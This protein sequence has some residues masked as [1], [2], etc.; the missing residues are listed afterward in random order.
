M[1]NESFAKEFME[2]NSINTFIQWIRYLRLNKCYNTSLLLCEFYYPM[3]S[4]NIY[5]LDEMG[6]CYYYT[7]HY[8]QS[9]AIYTDILSCTYL[10]ESQLVAF[11][12]NAHF[13]I[14]HIS[15][16]TEYPKSLVDKISS[17]VQPAGLVTLSI[18]TC[19]RYELFEKTVNSFLNHCIDI[20]LISRW[21][22]IDD[23][24]SEQDRIKMRSKYPF[25]E[26]VWKTIDQ[27]G[28]ASSM[29]MIKDMVDTPF[30]FHLEDDW[31][32]YYKASYI[33]P[34]LHVLYNDSTLGQ[35]LLNKN[36]SETFEDVSIHGG[37]F[38]TTPYGQRY[39][40]HEYQ[41]DDSLFR[42]KYGKCP[43][44]AYWPHFSLR[45]GMNKMCVWKK[46]G[47]FDDSSE[48]FELNYATRFMEE[49]FKTAFLDFMCCT[50]IGRLTRDRYDSSYANA[51]QLNGE[52]QFTRNVDNETVECRIINLDQRADRLNDIKERIKQQ[53][54]CYGEFFNYH[55]FSA[56]NGYL[57]APTRQMEQLFNNNDY[58]YRCGMIGCALSHISL[59]IE[60]S[61]S[62]K[63]YIILEDDV[64]FVPNFRKRVMH[65]LDIMKTTS[66]DVLFLGHHLYDS[67]KPKFEETKFEENK[68]EET[69][70]EETKFE[71]NVEKWST[72]Q[73]L[74]QSAGGTGGYIINNTGA[75]KMLS[76]IQSN[77]MTNGIDTM[78]QKACDTLDIYYCSPHL[79]YSDCYNIDNLHIDTDIQ[80]N[81]ESL[82][83]NISVRL[84]D[85]HEFFKEKGINVVV[86]NYEYRSNDGSSV[87]MCFGGCCSFEQCIE[88]C[89]EHVHIFIPISLVNQ[90]IDI[91]NVGLLHKGSFST[92]N[93]IAYK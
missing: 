49:G 77:G 71:D 2:T 93:L 83:R 37:I 80:K 20:H 44:V 23:N 21:I 25:F 65:I 47:T 9:W 69:K 17:N 78:M 34:C 43:S 55:R 64:T 32:F 73:S 54:D 39:Y 88:Y 8:Q 22:C 46:I 58:N 90:C 50:H 26:F 66:W 59:W 35:C 18:T 48:H 33:Q 40:I 31:Q 75:I 92:E 89:I 68:F 74:L 61:K 84:R 51:Y 41:P 63:P 36:Y 15:N 87:I 12:F 79:L 91:S 56:I 1:Q 14:P 28:H 11:T 38:Q 57:L 30:L 82:K 42:E 3:Y 24:S 4:Y 85:E 7:G 81:Y 29:N 53:I 10:N 19:K 27:K 76:F 6:M 62:A 16:D 67:Y 13:N 72:A 60:A 70:F 5:F 86:C 52:E 45:P